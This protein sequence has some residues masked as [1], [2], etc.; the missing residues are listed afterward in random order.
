MPISPRHS[1]Q[2]SK[3]LALMAAL[4]ALAALFF[5]LTLFKLS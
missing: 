1:Q 5:A 3:N 2:K 4:I